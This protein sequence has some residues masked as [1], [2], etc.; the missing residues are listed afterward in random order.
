MSNQRDLTKEINIKVAASNASDQ[1]AKPKIELCEDLVHQHTE[2]LLKGALG[3][4]FAVN[5]AQELVQSV[6]L[7]FFE[8]QSKFQGRSHIR[9]FL[10]GILYNKAKEKRREDTRLVPD[11]KIEELL[12]SH[13]DERGHWN[14]ALLDPERFL[15]A[16]QTK[17]L[18]E[19]CLDG[20]P[21]AQRMAFY[22]REIDERETPDIC[23]IL[24][25]TVT[26]L[27]VILFRAK[28]RLR[29]CIEHK[30]NREEL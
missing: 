14:S 11:E 26:N 19:N 27:G 1:A 22:L 21:L 20:L 2:I 4:G 23:N 12:N 8:I 9:T 7:T 10:F 18:I 28:T 15:Q 25:V 17:K 5:D 29:E 13:F 6:W 16:S 30:A 24:K 3:L